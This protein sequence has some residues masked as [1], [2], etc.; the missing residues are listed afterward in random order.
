M[1]CIQTLTGLKNTCDANLGGIKRAWFGNFDEITV[2]VDEATHTITGIT[3]GTLYEYE[4]N[5]QTG[6]LQ[7]TITVDEA[8]G[9]RFYTN[10]AALVFTKMEATKHAEIEALG[11]GHLVGIF[12]DNNL[13]PATG[14]GNMW[15]VGADNYMSAAELT[16]QTGTAFSD[17]NGYNTSLSQ[18]S[19]HL[20]YKIA[21][22]TFQSIIDA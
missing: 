4:F 5:R 22:S 7:S 20:P 15:F 1:G 6:S 11:R 12:E 8:N 10:T 21:Y 9:V 14:H 13:D 3:G 2:A 17:L 19:G 16:A 18:M